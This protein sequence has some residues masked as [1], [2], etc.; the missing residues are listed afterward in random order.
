[1][2]WDRSG[3][4]STLVW[5]HGLTSSRRDEDDFGLVDF[6]ALR[7]SADVVR[8]DARG[9]GES[10]ATDDPASS[11]WEQMAQDQLALADAL[12]VTKYIA[13]GASLGA[14]TALHAAVAAPDRIRA[15]VLV[16]PPTG[17]ETRADQVDMYDKMAAII[18]KR[19]VAAL[20]A[21]PPIPPPDPFT[22]DDGW[23]TRRN[24][25]MTAADPQR[26]AA[27]FRGAR[28][29]DLPTRSQIEVI[30]APTLILAW[31]GDPGHPVSS[32]EELDRLL[33]H[34]ELHIASTPADFAAWT[35][36]CLTFIGNLQLH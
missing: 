35:G 20:L 28:L 7:E 26:L 4:G 30:Q 5:G 6:A 15:L 1:M 23:A 3:A 2:A 14:A 24:D 33:P 21:A 12:G 10:T 34:S 11:T 36:R 27:Q 22:E 31:S 29:A 17:W 16:I 18:E 8:Y 25:K 9:H 19:G 13:G 32:A